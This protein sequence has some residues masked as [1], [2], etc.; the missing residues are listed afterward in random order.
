MMLATLRPVVPE[1]H[2]VHARTGLEDEARRLFSTPRASPDE[3]RLAN[4]FRKQLDHLFTFLYYPGVDATNN[5]AERQLRPAVISRKNSCGNRTTAGA[6]TWE[7]LTS[8]AAT[9]RQRGTSFID[10]AANSAALS[11]AF[12]PAR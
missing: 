4:R 10:L 5:L 7:V 1:D 12:A 9:C 8:L 11:P 2:F 6:A 3:E